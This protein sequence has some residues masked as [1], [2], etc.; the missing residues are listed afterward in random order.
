MAG[1][2][3]IDS[4][5]E[6]GPIGGIRYKLIAASEAG[7][8]TFLVPAQNCDEAKQNA[9][10]GLRLVKV[11]NLPGAVDSLESLNTGGDAPA[12]E[13]C[14][15]KRVRQSSSTSSSVAYSACTR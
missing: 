10:D 3:T 7:A 11:D 2:G 6:V 13:S 4:A 9:P 1:T 12:A 15:Q 8:E 14:L 5:G